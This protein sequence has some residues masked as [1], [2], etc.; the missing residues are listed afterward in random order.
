MHDV[1][2]MC[3]EIGIHSTGSLVHLVA[4]DESPFGDYLNTSHVCIIIFRTK[5]KA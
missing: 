4:I 5:Y 2:N 3:I 1:G